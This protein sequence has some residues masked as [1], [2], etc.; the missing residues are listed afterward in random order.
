MAGPGDIKLIRSIKN[1]NVEVVY[2]GVLNREKLNQLYTEIDFLL[3]P[4]LLEE[5]LGLTPIE[6]MAFGVPV[7]ASKIGAVTEYISDRKNGF[8]IE[9]G[10][11]DD[12]TNALMQNC[13]SHCSR[14]RQS[15]QLCTKSCR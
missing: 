12:M 4:T 13:R 10:S 2:C 9:P 15:S 6:A 3:F 5:S 11:V 1:L 8:F 7:V 14:I